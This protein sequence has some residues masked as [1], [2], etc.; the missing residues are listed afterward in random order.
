MP[1]VVDHDEYR[2][3]LLEKCFHLF[4]RKGYSKVTMREIAAETGVSTGTLY[5]YFP[6]KQK[7]FEQMFAFVRET[8]VGEYLNRIA[9]VELMSE[10]LEKIADFWK[11]KGE[12]Y[13]N[14]M[15]LA[16]DLHRSDSTDDT[17]KIFIDFSEYYT[18]TMSDRLNISRQF[19]KSIFIYLLGLVFHSL[20]T[21]NHISYSDQISIVKNIL[22][23]VIVKG[24][25]SESSDKIIIKELMNILSSARKKTEK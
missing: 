10:R 17:E 5:H 12:F 14:L 4:S 3:E 2:K 8:N 6:T 23:T 7:I 15:L 19:A 11:D 9:D 22:E 13:Q 21:P 1:K 20:L 24:I 25:Q 18:G 16:I